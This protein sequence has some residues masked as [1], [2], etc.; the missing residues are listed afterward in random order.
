M[1]T[2]T[3][4]L[5]MI[6]VLITFIIVL[7]LLV[8][9][10]INKTALALIGATIVAIILYILPQPI[11]GTNNRITTSLVWINIPWDTIMFIFS[12]MMIVGMSSKS[13]LFQYIAVRTIQT[14]K[15]RPKC[16]YLTFIIITFLISFIFD[17]VT[18]MLI[19]APITIEIMDIIERDFRPY[20]I[21][22]AIVANFGSIPSLI[23][24]VPNIVVGGEADL[25]FLQ[26]IVVLGPLSL[27][28]LVV[29]IPIL[30]Y[31]HRKS[32]EEVD[33]S[34]N[35]NEVLNDEYT[36]EFE[37]DTMKI[38]ILDPNIVIKDRSLFIRS[39]I[40]VTVLIM[41]FTLGQFL[42]Y[43]FKPVFVAM[44]A[45]TIILLGSHAKIKE[46]LKDVQWETIF[47]IIGLL[48]IVQAME[49]LGVITLLASSL[50]NMLVNT[51][52]IANTVLILIGWV[53]SGVVD[54]IPISAALAP[55][56]TIIGGQGSLIAL[57][58]VFG[59]N[60]G[61]YILPISSPANIL[62]LSFAEKSDNPISFS[63]FM[64]V[65]TTLAILH[66]IIGIIYFSLFGQLFS[67]IVKV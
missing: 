36:G 40:A 65:G 58:L 29:S 26:F 53:L 38:M 15:G 43:P 1:A 64:K 55:I 16:L 23:G 5:T 39:I 13:G 62:A 48:F 51:P 54:N 30:L 31:F 25:T 11:V 24:S 56:A 27:I 6:L 46:Y 3:L 9:E 10:K 60:V 50:Q 19:I 47:F 67:G 41:G 8:T 34:G 33:I 59:I 32:F 45:M 28:L 2:A 20:L 4:D 57:G 44:L 66:L 17:T 52:G 22:E 37:N 18:T 14:T 35:S 61:G 7:A 42:P 21:A 12:M 63:D 49:L